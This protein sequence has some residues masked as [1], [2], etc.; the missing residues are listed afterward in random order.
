MRIGKDRP[1]GGH[2]RASES[3]GRGDDHAISRIRVKG[4][5]K[6]HAL[7]RNA[8]IQW[9]KTQT[10]KCDNALEPSINR[11]I[12]QQPAVFDEHGYFP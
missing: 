2:K 6:A 3:A 8:R 1:I 11:F 12:K 7:N 10:W 9:H 5:W 4:A